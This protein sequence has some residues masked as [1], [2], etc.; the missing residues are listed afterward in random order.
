MNQRKV[1][2]FI[3]ALLLMAGAA[4]LLAQFHHH[5]RLGAP[6]VRTHRLDPTRLQAELP[7]QV[8]NY[9]SRWIEV[10][11]M[12]RSTLPQDTSFGHRFYLGPDGFPVDVNVVLMGVDRTSLHKPQ[13]CLEG[14]GYHID[15]TKS[16]E[17]RVH[18]ERPYSYDLPVVK[19]VANSERTINGQRETVRLVYV[20]WYVADDAMSASA[21]GAERMWLMT[22]RL[23]RTGVLQR[24]AYISCL[25]VCA[26][27]Q[28]DAS[29]ERIKTFIAAAVPEFQLFPQP[30]GTVARK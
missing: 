16:E 11:S 8:L 20:Y 23:L 27:G 29:F 12:T 15:Q 6:G 26:P 9:T 10:D 24:W 22:K 30:A 21:L 4:G 28:E 19:L 7:E 14:Q 5:Q 2:F 25:S 17:T 18:I 13:F 3:V 1:I